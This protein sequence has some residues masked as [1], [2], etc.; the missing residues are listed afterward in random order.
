MPT[1][2]PPWLRR[3]YAVPQGF[4]RHGL[5]R[6][7]GH[8]FVRLTH[9]GRTSGRRHHAFVE[10]VRYDRATGEAVVWAGY[11]RRSDWYRNIRAGG[12][13]WVDFGGGERP[14][15]FR[16]IAPDEAVGVLA[17][18]ERGYGPLRPLLLRVVAAFAGFDYRGTDEDRR[19]AAEL[20]PMIALTPRR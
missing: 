3:L 14:A 5:G 12:P 6:L 15:R 4:Y 20:L 11:G 19:R 17:T 7:F 8:R 1:P 2:P 10:V 13:V 16:E 9:T 18:Y